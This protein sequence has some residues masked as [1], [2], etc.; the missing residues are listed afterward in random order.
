MYVV[1]EG[2]KD[3]DDVF[4]GISDNEDFAGSASL[5]VDCEVYNYIGIKFECKLNDRVVNE[6]VIKQKGLNLKGDD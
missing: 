4:K 6:I 3:I 2:G 5:V 1:Y